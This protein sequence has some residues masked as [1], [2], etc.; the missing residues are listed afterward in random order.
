MLALF[1]TSNTTNDICIWSKSHMFSIQSVDNRGKEFYRYWLRLR[2]TVILISNNRTSALKKIN[3][4]ALIRT[5][6]VSAI[7]F[8]RKYEELYSFGR[9]YS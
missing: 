5:L 1:Q 2:H 8:E 7:A 9:L 4:M 6:T 3:Q